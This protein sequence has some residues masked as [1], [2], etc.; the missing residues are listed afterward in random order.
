MTYLQLEVANPARPEVSETVRFGVDSGAMNSVVPAAVL[1]RLGIEPLSEQQFRMAN[2]G[3]I[4]RRRGG[5]VFHFR[6]R[7]GVADVVFGERGDANLL[8]ATTLESLGLGLDPI[9]RE[10]IELEMTL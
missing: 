4:R 8:G 10:L 3:I 7:V 5:A 1:E 6:E 2:G 9:R